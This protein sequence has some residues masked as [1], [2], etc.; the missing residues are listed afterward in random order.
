MVS[1][2]VQE[3]QHPMFR[4]A[5]SLL[6]AIAFKMNVAGYPTNVGKA[7]V[8][9]PDEK[10]RVH[11]YVGTGSS[12]GQALAAKGAVYS[13]VSRAF[14]DY[15]QAKEVY[16]YITSNLKFEEISPFARWENILWALKKGDVEEEI[17]IVSR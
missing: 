15:A 16:D 12:A 4:T 1:G 5:K 17:D 2:Q 7:L 8:V 13:R 10:Y 11:V 9:Y 3:E 6:R 14:D